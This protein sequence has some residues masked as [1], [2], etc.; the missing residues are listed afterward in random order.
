MCGIAGLIT[1][2][3]VLP[4]EGVLRRMTDL[5]AHRGPDG[6]GIW[7]SEG[8]G[9]G[10]RRLAIIDLS[11]QGAQPMH[12]VDGRY[13][14]TYNGEIYNYRD[15]REDL[16]Q[17][18]S[19][20]R[21]ESDTEVVLEVYR[22][23]GKECVKH[24]RGMFA[25]A[26]WDK[27]EKRCFIARDRAGK[28]P[29]FYRTLSD[30]TIAF[31]SE[32]KALRPIENVTVDECAIR[33]FIGLQYVPAPRTGLNEISDL[34]PGHRGDIDERGITI[35][36]YNNWD[37]IPVE[38][39]DDVSGDLLKILD[40]AVRLRLQADVRVG[41]FLSGG[42]D[43]AACVALAQRHTTRPIRTFTM[44]FPYIKM[45]ERKEA[46]ET[47][48]YFGT[49]HQEFEAQP[50]SLI[51]LMDK[52]IYQYG[53]PYADS[54]ALPVMLLSREVAQQIKV[55]LVGDG[56]DELFGGYRRYSAY[57]KACKLMRL[58]C[59]KVII[60]PVLKKIA[61]QR[62][63]PRFARIAETIIA[64]RG[65]TNRGYAELFCGSYFSTECARECFRS[66]FLDRTII[67]DPVDFIQ[68]RMGTKGHPLERAMRFD[69]ESYLAD[70]LN[71]KMDRATMAYGLEARA[72]FLDLQM[73]AYALGLPLKLRRNCVNSKIALK[74]AM[75]GIL[76]DEILKRKKR[77]FQVP[78]ADW[79]RG[80]LKQYWSDHCL[81]ERSPLA[82]YVR[83][84]QIR[85]MFE[86]NTR[87]ADHGNRLWMLLALSVWLES[88][89]SS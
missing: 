55:V 4:D 16:A 33:Q 68:K 54:S 36:S 44:G 63:D 17:K 21:S 47:A 80:S 66:D 46:K 67:C 43:S 72:P 73:V 65:D 83:Q 29:F 50:E 60:A 56:G 2:R 76:P 28:K 62:R 53:G 74:H 42:I 81:D 38:R 86:E 23:Y 39:T 1:K 52:L 31:A 85:K 5:L 32:M 26:I 71:V 78:L 89:K 11:E 7:R 51:K 49:D 37:D 12:S 77:G 10:H 59:S 13:T 30:G 14:I 48:K 3:D 40:E 41:A 69:F 35:E 61:K 84:D 22:H 20:F 24:L 18:G 88:V 9:L 58:P 75:K 25:F 6:Q 27:D 87:G 82:D 57:D 79:F 8:V 45:D 64:G 19:T 15:L 70:D 34:P